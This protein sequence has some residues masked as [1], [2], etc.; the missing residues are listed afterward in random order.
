[1]I[2]LNTKL[3]FYQLLPVLRPATVLDVGSLDGTHAMRFRHLVPG[4]RIVAFE[5]NPRNVAALRDSGAFQ[6]AGIELVPKAASN[7]D[8]HLTFFVEATSAAE[9]WR[10]GISSTRQR[11]A[12]S[13]GTVPT[14]VDAVR[15]DTF[16]T[17][18]DDLGA[19]IALWVDVEGAS[20][21]VLQGIEAIRTRVLV[22]HCEVETRPFWVGQHLKA[23][24]EA[25]LGGFGFTCV[26]R[27][28]LDE[29]HDLVYIRTDALP[30]IGWRL[31]A[32]LLRTWML[33]QAQKH[34]GSGRF[35]SL[36]ERYLK[37]TSGSALVA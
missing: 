13:L 32:L 2:R 15:L 4:A 5:A 18:R 12:A 1:M 33:T 31:R 7:H 22:I 14:D 27:G 34:L 37:R 21:E 20:Y 6:S 10:H 36:G 19:P 3:L 30:A 25:L 8:G 11:T 16:V 26:A 24:V 9:P 23:D 17:A 35:R 29:Q 28:P